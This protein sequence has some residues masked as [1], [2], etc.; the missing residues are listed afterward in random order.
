MLFIGLCRWYFN[1]TITV[2][3]II[4]RPVFYLKRN[5]SE[6]RFCLCLQMEPTELDSIDKKCKMDKK[7]RS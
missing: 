2:L 4:Y 7:I 1:I 6:N 3:D 5:V